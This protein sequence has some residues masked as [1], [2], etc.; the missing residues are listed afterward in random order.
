MGH[1]CHVFF[2]SSR[3]TRSTRLDTIR[4]AQE[5][6]SVSATGD[7]CSGVPRIIHTFIRNLLSLVHMGCVALPMAGGEHPPSVRLDLDGIAQSALQ[8]E[9]IS[10]SPWPGFPQHLIDALLQG[11]NVTGSTPPVC[12][13]WNEAV[14]FLV[15]ILWMSCGESVGSQRSSFLSFHA[16]ESLSILTNSQY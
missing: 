6:C 14:A 8:Q 3:F 1:S 2:C 5:C 7:R 13:C 16:I 4:K 9:C 15:R 11:K 12:P 10:L